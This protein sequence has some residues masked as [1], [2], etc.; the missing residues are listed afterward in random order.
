M[1]LAQ[2]KQ[3]PS[4]PRTI[5]E[6]AFYTLLEKIIKGY[7]LPEYKRIAYDSSQ[8]NIILA[9][10]Q[11][12]QVFNLIAE[13]SEIELKKTIEKHLESSEDQDA[14]F[15]IFDKVR[16]SKAL[17]KKWVFDAAK[18]SDAQKEQLVIIDN[19]NDGDW[20]TELL[21]NLWQD[22]EAL[23]WVDIKLPNVDVDFEGEGESEQDQAIVKRSILLEYT[24][25]EH[26]IVTKE[27][28]KHGDTLEDA[29][30]NVLKLD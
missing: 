13:M 3:N 22:S 23:K 24:D 26:E 25:E 20:D 18:L 9:G 15:A 30:W 4:N 5:K 17:P 28:R 2:L 7:Q 10:N 19:V 11:R 1:K 6:K 29:L 27:L 12:H 8:E 16:K 21:A 14:A